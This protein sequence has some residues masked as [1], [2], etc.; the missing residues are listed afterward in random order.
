MAR[1]TTISQEEVNAAADSIRA[2]GGRPTARAVREQLGRGSM[3]TVLRLLQTWQA[4]QAVAPET[5]VVLPTGLQRALLD[6]TAQEVAAAKWQLEQELVTAQQTQKELIA[7]NEAQASA[8]ADLQ[9]A[10]EELQVDHSR[11]SGRYE[12]IGTEFEETRQTVESHR[13]AAETARTEIAKLLLKLEGVPR[14]EADLA[15]LMAALEAERV[16]RVAAD[17]TAAV[18]SALLEQSQAS[19][20]DLKI[21]LARAESDAREAN[22]EAGRLR[23]QVSTVQGALDSASKQ[24]SQ[25]Q[26]EVRLAEASAAELKGQLLALTKTQQERSR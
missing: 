3:A 25:S 5:P 7:E 16:A 23:E 10:L 18:A 8:L 22:H 4:G 9:R 26:N 12:Q 6:F 11:L 24:L 14:L 20:E 21:R 2:A 19:V 15:K 17:Q 13:Q 1:G